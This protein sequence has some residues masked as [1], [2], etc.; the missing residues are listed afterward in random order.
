MKGKNE[1]RSEKNEGKERG[2]EKEEERK[3]TRV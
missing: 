3:A 2:C 1:S